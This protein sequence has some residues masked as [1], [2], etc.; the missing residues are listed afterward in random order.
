MGTLGCLSFNGNKIISAGGGGMIL[1]D[2]EVLAEKAKYLTTQAKDDGIRYIHNDI[3]YNYRLTNIQAAMGVA[4]LEQLPGYLKIKKRNYQRYKN[5]IDDISGLH[6]AKI[7]EYAENNH[8][9]YALQ[10]DKGAYGKDREQLMTCPTENDIQ[11]RPVWQ[12]NHMQKPYRSCQVYQIERAKD[13]ID[14]TI[15]IPCSMNLKEIEIDYIIKILK[16]A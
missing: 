5:E 6:I 9:M 11:T 8:W 2:N 12:L 3:G 4:Q 15:N 1:T 13:L 16:N 14:K 10:I 7:P